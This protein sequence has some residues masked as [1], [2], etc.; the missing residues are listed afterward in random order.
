MLVIEQLFLPT[1]LNIG[2]LN[3]LL[4]Q[5]DFRLMIVVVITNAE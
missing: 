4:Y 2:T 5:D 1:D 3:Y